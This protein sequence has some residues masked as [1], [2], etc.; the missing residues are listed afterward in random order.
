MRL[1]AITKLE[2]TVFS[3]TKKFQLH[4]IPGIKRTVKLVYSVDVYNESLVKY[5]VVSTIVYKTHDVGQTFESE[6]TTSYWEAMRFFNAEVDRGESVVSE[7]R[8]KMKEVAN[9]W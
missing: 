4:G 5:K 1:E 6:E 8:T 9:V 3:Q 7:M 2:G